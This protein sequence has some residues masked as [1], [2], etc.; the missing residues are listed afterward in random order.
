MLISV[1]C[2][3]Y[4][5]QKMVWFIALCRRLLIYVKT[6]YAQCAANAYSTIHLAA[7]GMKT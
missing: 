4:D 3:Q 2:R 7:Q 1:G 6:T 5:L